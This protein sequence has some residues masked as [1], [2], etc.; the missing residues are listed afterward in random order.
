M[1]KFSRENDKLLWEKVLIL[2][3][4]S[5]EESDLDDEEEV[6][7]LR[8]LP[9]RAEKVDTLFRKLDDITLKAKSP[10]ARR[11]M[12]RRVLGVESS[13]SSPSIAGIPSWAVIS[14]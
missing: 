3:F 6:L 8:P 12:K 10:Q 5:S 13:R 9:W 1:M 2:G 14:D 4:M 11:Q 7:S